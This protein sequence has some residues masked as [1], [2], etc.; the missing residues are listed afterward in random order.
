MDITFVLRLR[1]SNP[2]GDP[3]ALPGW[4]REFDISG[5]CFTPISDLKKTSTSTCTSTSTSTKT[6]IVEVHVLVDVVVDGLWLRSGPFEGS[7][8]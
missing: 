5:V 7:Q 2:L 1:R 3:P 6:V 4:Q 8:P